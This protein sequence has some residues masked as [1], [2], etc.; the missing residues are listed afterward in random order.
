MNLVAMDLARS[1]IAGSP[2]G[3]EP[4]VVL[5]HAALG[6]NAGAGSLPA[7]SR[8]EW[9]PANDLP[10]AQAGA[11]YR[12]ALARDPADESSRRALAAS[13]AMRG[14]DHALENRVAAAVRPRPGPALP[15]TEADPLARAA[16]HL[17]MPAE[18]RRM[19]LE[20]GA[21]PSAALR[22]TRV[23]D[24]DLA[25]WNFEAADAGYR[26]ALELDPD[27]ADASVGRALCALEQGQAGA[28]VEAARAFLKSAAAVDARRRAMFEQI[29][30]FCAAQ[31]LRH[32]R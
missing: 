24:T 8:L 32:A 14:M 23:A 11:A 30:A 25:A 3:A 5:G 29:E 17:G 26:L 13:L 28:A 16:L 12:A 31:A 4:W 27:L 20:A 7:G 22:A 2:A 21:C 15:W 19:W 18:A 6:L 9:D 10:W 1:V